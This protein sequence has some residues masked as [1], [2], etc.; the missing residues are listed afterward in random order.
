MRP[1]LPLRL[2]PLVLLASCHAPAAPAPEAAPAESA[3][4]A[5]YAAIMRQELRGAPFARERAASLSVVAPR[6]PSGAEADGR[7]RRAFEALTPVEQ[8]DLLEWFTVECEKLRT[9]QVTLIQYIVRAS[10]RDPATWP[11]LVAS[12]WYDAQTHSPGQPIPREPLAAEANEVVAVRNQI[13]A[14]VGSRRLDSGWMV[15]YAQRSLVRLAHQQDPRRV[16]E[17]A[18]LGMAPDWD[19]A[20]ALVELA[21]DDGSQQ[22]SFQAFAHAYTDRWGGVYPGVT[23]YDAYASQTTVEMPDVDTLGIVHDLLGDWDTWK[24]PV[25]AE[26]H[27]PLYTRI[28]ELF[29]PLLRHRGLRTNLARTYLCGSAEL[30]DSY[31]HNLDNFHALWESVASEP[32]ALKSKLPDSEGWDAFLQG[33]DDTLYATPEVFLKGA[34]RHATLERDAQRVR[35]T[36]LRLLGEYGAYARIETLPP[37]DQ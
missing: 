37:F 14:A 16:F 33:W 6:E 35:A 2:A 30:R 3:A 12:P 21:L 15:D 5:D 36:L 20:E 4:P 10:E 19:L 28:A 1:H 25:S 32:A 11:E 7:A 23:L 9:F 24:A 27:E 18:L 17:N 13:L 26:Q 22:K 31:T 29:R 34:S 8:A